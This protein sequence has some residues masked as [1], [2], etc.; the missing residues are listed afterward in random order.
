MFSYTTRESI[1]S[2]SDSRIWYIVWLFYYS[3]S[4]TNQADTI[5]PEFGPDF[6]TKTHFT[7]GC[8]SQDVN[9]TEKY[10]YFLL[11]LNDQEPLR[12]T[13]NISKHRDVFWMFF[14]QERSVELKPYLT[15]KSVLWSTPIW[16]KTHCGALEPFSLLCQILNQNSSND[17]HCY[18]LNSHF[19][20]R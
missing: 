10:K 7:Q 9:M 16:T 3:Y 15:T 17:K 19:R 13:Q 6:L 12:K 18:N 14:Q 8:Y 5:C 11:C 2:L 1:G 20:I 4:T